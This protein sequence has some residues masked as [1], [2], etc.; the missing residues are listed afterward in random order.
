VTFK[1]QR[2]LDVDAK[3]AGAGPA[4]HFRSI[5]ALHQGLSIGDVDVPVDVTHTLGSDPPIHTAPKVGAIVTTEILVDGKRMLTQHRHQRFGARFPAKALPDD[6]PSRAWLK[7]EEAAA[8][9]ELDFKAGERALEIG[10]APGGATFNLLNRGLFVVG[11]DPNPMDPNIAA[12]PKF[13]HVMA[14]S[15]GKPSVEGRFQWLLLDVNVPPG[16]ALRGLAPYAEALER[17]LKGAVLTLKL[18]SWDIVNEI[19]GWMSRIARMMPR[20]DFHVTQLWS[21]GREICV[22]GRR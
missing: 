15:T 12:H 22:V 8:R 20:L 1:A 4:Q 11:M 7:L 19:P 5:F 21:N 17:D 16:T 3:L 6:A 9:F 2:E 14:P 13:T 10:S 18:K